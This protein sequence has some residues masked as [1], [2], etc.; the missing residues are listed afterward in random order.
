MVP[1][2]TTNVPVFCTLTAARKEDAVAGKDRYDPT[3][4]SV[5]EVE[6]QN[7]AVSIAVVSTIPAVTSPALIV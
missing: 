4:P 1:S 7:L 2:S 6:F 5:S 3:A